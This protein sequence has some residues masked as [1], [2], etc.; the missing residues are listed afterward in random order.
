MTKKEYNE[1]IDLAK[2]KLDAVN[3][4]LDILSQN[5]NA[6]QLIKGQLETDLENIQQ[7][8]GLRS[9]PYHG[10]S[11]SQYTGLTTKQL[12]LIERTYRSFLKLLE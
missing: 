2:A 11:H 8:I 12:D 1:L 4:I 5:G 7:E 6:R 10:G 9:I 3:N